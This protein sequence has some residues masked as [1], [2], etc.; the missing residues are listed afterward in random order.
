M[1][2]NVEEAVSKGSAAMAEV[3]NKLLAAGKKMLTLPASFAAIRDA[4]F[5]ESGQALG[6]LEALE[7]SA[8]ARDIAGD[9]AAAELRVA[10]FHRKLTQ[11]AGELGI[12]LI[13]PL[14]GTR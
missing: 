11:R 2:M 7:L 10:T 9:I 1:H 13:Q 4:G 3:E 14:G 12:D 6:S 8:E 5:L